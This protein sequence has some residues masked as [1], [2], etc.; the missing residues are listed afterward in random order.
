MEMFKCIS[1]GAEKESEEACSCSVCGYRMF[2]MPYVRSRV[3]IKEIQNFIGHLKLSDLTD[4]AA[5]YYRKVL[6]ESPDP[7]N[8]DDYVVVLKLSDDQEFPDYHKIIEFV[9]CANKTEIFLERLQ[10]SIQQIKKH[11]HS[12]RKQQYFYSIEDLR[13]DAK[14]LDETLVK[15]MEVLGETI[16][17]EPIQY[18]DPQVDYSEIP[19]ESLLP[20]ADAILDALMQMTEKLRK[21]IRQNNAYGTAYQY[22]PKRSFKRSED[23]DDQYDLD[24]CLNAVQKALDKKYVVDLFED[25]TEEIQEMLRI[26]WKAIDG[27]LTV[28]VRKPVYEYVFQDGT[29]FA[30]EAFKNKILN[31][32]SKRYAKVD[33][34]IYAFD[35]L[36]SKTEDELFNLYDQMI[37]LDS[38]DFMG[39][40]REGLLKIGESENR[41]NTLIGLSTIKDSIRKIKAYALK[42]KDKES[43]NLHMCFYGNPGTGKTEV[44]RIIAGI[45]YENKILP[46]KKVVEV[47]RG[48]LIGQY[49]GETPQKTMRKIREAMGGVLFIDEAYALVPKDGTF[50]Y[51]NEAIATLIK[52]MEDHRGEFCVILA[53]YKN[54][55]LQMIATNPGFKSRIQFELDFPNYSR[56]ELKSITELMLKKREYTISEDALNKVLDITDIKRKEPNFANAREIRN[57]LD[58]VIMCQ[59]VRCAGTDDQELGLTDVNKYIVDAKI[60]LPMGEGTSSNKILTGEEELDQLIGLAT[61]KRMVKKIK[62][63]AKKNKGESGFNLHMCFFGNPG[64]GKTEVARIISRI[65][66][67]AGVLA[68]AKIVET[69]AHGLLG[70][71]VGQ[72]APKTLE[73]INEAMNGV[74]FIDEAYGLV[75]S[76]TSS[77]GVTSYGEEAIAVLL[78]EME[79]HRGQFCVILAGYRE[80]MKT[81]ISA[82]PGLESRIQFTLEFPDYT[83][84]ELG[85]IAVSFLKK[86]KYQINDDALNRLLD[87]TEYFR[88]QD[89]FANAR[90]V[91]NILDQV[92]MN[93]NLRTEDEKDNQTI[94]IDDVEDYLTD[95]GIDLKKPAEKKRT[96]GFA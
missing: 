73:K 6:P 57:I 33:E 11:L 8:P 62:A 67:D 86:K 60:N 22:V 7:N 12:E 15:A 48:G 82:N 65:L 52:A 85:E 26:V 31:D 91:R 47:D 29:I 39:V 69:D 18:D 80:E 25:G 94:I 9:S 54:E 19:D 17:L 36:E 40:N 1:C 42:N 27:L 5:R 74:L 66:Y 44:A 63:Y 81:M 59:N 64:T 14:P 43:L 55:M 68:E 72:T 92:V 24:C 37:A 84:E 2:Q 13:N 75:S 50:D 71:Y 45:L 21:F 76:G 32:I 93:Q 88:N 56:D 95:E 61:V 16:Q 46:T 87:I 23:E 77:G 38:F 10:T 83:R 34:I 49:V 35:F 3:L 79:D 90:T 78:K 89:N 58:Q 41:L 70:Q 4:S 20:T 30:S 96:I 28:P 51:G 53:G